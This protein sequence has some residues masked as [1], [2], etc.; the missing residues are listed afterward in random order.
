MPILKV[1]KTNRRGEKLIY[2]K[3]GQHVIP[4]HIK[5][6]PILQKVIKI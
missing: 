4:S 6:K 5:L 3:K 1:T 2:L